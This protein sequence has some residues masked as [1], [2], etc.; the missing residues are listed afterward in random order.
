M[1]KAGED[2]KKVNNYTHRKNGKDLAFIILKIP[3][4]P[5]ENDHQ[6]HTAESFSGFTDLEFTD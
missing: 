2:P 3:H 1:Q 5:W 6:I 4:K